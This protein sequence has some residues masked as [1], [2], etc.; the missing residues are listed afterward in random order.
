MTLVSVATWGQGSISTTLKAGKGNASADL[1]LTDST[2]LCADF[3]H[4]VP[5]LYSR[6][7]APLSVCVRTNRAIWSVKSMNRKLLPSRSDYVHAFSEGEMSNRD[8]QVEWGCFPTEGRN[9]KFSGFCHC[10]GWRW[11][12]EITRVSFIREQV[13]KEKS[14]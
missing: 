11:T 8:K 10:G 5:A 14:I 7:L 2:F 9:Q 3:S 13:Y 6:L 1:S 4:L 12:W